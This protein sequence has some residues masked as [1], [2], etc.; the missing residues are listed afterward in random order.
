VNN[1]KQ[2]KSKEL[3]TDLK[4]HQN[5]NL[6]RQNVPKKSG[7]EG[8]IEDEIKAYIRFITD[9]NFNCICPLLF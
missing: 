7:N 9:V 1:E 2:A 6:V 8:T 3:I 4:R 5:Y